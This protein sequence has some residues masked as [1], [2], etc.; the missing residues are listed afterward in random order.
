M[1]CLYWPSVQMC[2]EGTAL[3]FQVD[4]VLF[5]NLLLP[6]SLKLP[7]NFRWLNIAVSCFTFGSQTIVQHREPVNTM[8]FPLTASWTV[9]IQVLGGTKTQLVK[10]IGRV[11]SN[12]HCSAPG[13]IL[14]T[15]ENGLS[16]SIPSSLVRKIHQFICVEMGVGRYPWSWVYF[17]H[18][19]FR[20]S[21]SS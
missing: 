19:D 15:C 7:W 6:N 20:I 3:P 5:H 18:C 1:T 9:R 13:W 17:R 14:Q 8:C 2:V 10:L 16:F 4:A 12:I 21:G 11:G